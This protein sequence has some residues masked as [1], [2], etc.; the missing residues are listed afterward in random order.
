MIDNYV[1]FLLIGDF[2]NSDDIYINYLKNNNIDNIKFVHLTKEDLI[3]LVNYKLNFN[4]YP[5]KCCDLRP[6]Y[7]VI[8]D[9]YITNYDYWGHTDIDLFYG[10]LKEYLCNIDTNIEVIT[11]AEVVCGSFQLYKNN[12]KINNLFKKTDYKFIL[13]NGK[14]FAFDEGFDG[15]IG[16]NKNI[17]RICQLINDFIDKKNILKKI[18]NTHIHNGHWSNH[19][20][21]VD[22]IYKNNLLYIKDFKGNIVKTGCIHMS[23]KK[24]I[25][26]SIL[27]NI[28]IDFILNLKEIKFSII[29]NKLYF[30]NNIKSIDQ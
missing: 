30:L 3:K 8:F 28:S 21:I 5:Y 22:I 25:D 13:E 20:L 11:G 12:E 14:P 26:F 24:N 4:F 18:F 27:E 19:S 2:E 23:T 16:H 1:D 29:N 6:T 9:D 17:K 10:S 15:Q 7:G